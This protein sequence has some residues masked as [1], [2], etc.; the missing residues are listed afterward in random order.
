MSEKHTEK[1]NNNATIGTYNTKAKYLWAIAG[2]I[3]LGAIGSGVWEMIAKPGLSSAGRFFL[4]IITFGSTTIKDWAYETASFDPYPLPALL[5]QACVVWLIT[6]LISFKATVYFA[7]L[8]LSRRKRDNDSESTPLVALSNG[9]LVHPIDNRLEDLK[10]GTSVMV[11]VIPVI[12]FI[13][14][15]AVI[16]QAILVKRSF[17][18]NMAICAPALSLQEEKILR[19]RYASIR[20]KSQHAML[21]SDLERLCQ[22]KGVALRD[23][24][25]W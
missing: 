2:T 4:N 15:G 14:G 6:A 9:E 17:E 13:A 22:S 18:T 11:F 23:F 12:G 24:P 1:V 5:V 8:L 25:T 19:S 21:V 3:V 16:N 7:K 10:R 20:T